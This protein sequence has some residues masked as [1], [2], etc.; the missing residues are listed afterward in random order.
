MQAF[1]L[2]PDAIKAWGQRKNVRI[3]E[4]AQLKQL[5]LPHPNNPDTHIRF[6]PRPDRNLLTMAVPLKFEVPEDRVAPF[7]EALSL[8][9]SSTFAGAWTYNHQRNEPYF[10]ITVP[11]IG[12][13][14]TDA[15]LEFLVR[16]MFGSVDG[17]GPKLMKVALEGADPKS[18]IANE[19]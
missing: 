2:T 1:A 7:C 11:T 18:V 4:N 12:T 3:L 6:I 5:A 17:M 14:Y 15:S 19:G 16:V 10:R 8:A 13:G 9:N